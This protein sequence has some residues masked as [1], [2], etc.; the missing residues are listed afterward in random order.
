[1]LLNK[2]CDNFRVFRIKTQDLPN[3]FLLEVKIKIKNSS[4]RAIA[5][6]VQ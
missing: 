1:M 4:V 3:V 2:I 6:F 5:H